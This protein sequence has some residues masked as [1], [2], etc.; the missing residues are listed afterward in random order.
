VYDDDG[1]LTA[2]DDRR[3]PLRT[4]EPPR[5]ASPP[6]SEFAPTKVGGGDLR[7]EITADVV[8]VSHQWTPED[9]S[10]IRSFTACYDKP[11]ESIRRA[12]H[13][14]VNVVAAIDPRCR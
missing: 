6:R 3:P 4:L 2:A 11:A 8:E 9:I 10:G 12:E 5:S 13:G 14:V 1:R 7:G